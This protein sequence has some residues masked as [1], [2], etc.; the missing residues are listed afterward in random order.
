MAP[1]IMLDDNNNGTQIPITSKSAFDP[2]KT[3]GHKRAPGGKGRT[4]EKDTRSSSN[5]MATQV[6]SSPLNNKELQAFYDAI[7]LKS[8]GFVLPNSYFTEATLNSVQSS[9]IC[10][11]IPKCG[12]N[13][14]TSRA[15]IFGPT[16]LAGAGFTPLYL[17]QGKGQ[18]LQFLKYWRTNTPTSRLLQIT[19]SW[20]Q[21][22]AGTSTS[23]LTTVDTN[24]PHLESRWLPSL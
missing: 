8:I 6:S 19:T 15:V 5:N 7:Y 1:Q 2:H 12:Y 18:I 16:H 9:A 4:Q 21:F 10:A 22:Q 24:L 17:L 14:S 3:L 11:F 13:R 23:I 20:C